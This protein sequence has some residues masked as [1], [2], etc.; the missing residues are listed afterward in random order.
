MNG[1]SLYSEKLFEKNENEAENGPL[2][3]FTSF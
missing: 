2:D 1:S 3:K